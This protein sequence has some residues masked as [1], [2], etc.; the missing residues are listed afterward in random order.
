MTKTKTAEGAATALEQRISVMNAEDEVRNLQ[1]AYGY[2][3]DR[4]MWDDV[5]YLFTADGALEVANLGVYD[6]PKSIRRALER[7]GPAGLKHGQLNELMQLDMAVAI[8]PSGM[9][10]RGRGLELGMLGEADK[11]T[12][13]Y[14]LAIFENR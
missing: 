9:E 5:T 12:A 2:Y 8:E 14:T 4:K 7:S 6:G 11:G 1:N 3:M 10:A 13:F